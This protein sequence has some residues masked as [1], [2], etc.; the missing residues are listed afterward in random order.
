MLPSCPKTL[1]KPF[2]FQKMITGKTSVQLSSILK[3]AAKPCTGWH[4]SLIC[5]LTHGTT[6]LIQ[7]LHSLMKFYYLWNAALI[8][9][10]LLAEVS[11]GMCHNVLSFF[12]KRNFCG[13]VWEN[14][15]KGWLEKVGSHLSL[16]PQ[17]DIWRQRHLKSNP[18]HATRKGVSLNS[19]MLRLNLEIALSHTR[20]SSD[21]LKP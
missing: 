17:E 14:S 19:S 6:L 12:K 9:N 1:K 11:N 18:V 8:K 16:L 13:T 10:A 5:Q 15:N 3:N 20:L 7:D 2:D 4:C 21:F